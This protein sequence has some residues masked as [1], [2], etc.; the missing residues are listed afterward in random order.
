M[1]ILLTTTNILLVGML[2]LSFANGWV[3][4]DD[5]VKKKVIKAASSV[6][7]RV[8]SFYSRGEE[9]VD[10]ARAEIADKVEVVEAVSE[11]D[12]VEVGVAPEPAFVEVVLKEDPTV[13]EASPDLEET[14]VETTRSI[15]PTKASEPEASVLERILNYEEDSVLSRNRSSSYRSTVPEEPEEYAA[16]KRKFD[17]NWRRPSERL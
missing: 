17:R 4:V 11:A 15:E 13:F 6:I 9:I 12:E 1:R 16:N 2:A 8:D 7:E 5:E 10:S 3:Y 14:P